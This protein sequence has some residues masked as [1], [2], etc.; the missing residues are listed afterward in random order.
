MLQ[1]AMDELFGG[2]RAQLELTGVRRP[3]AKGHLVVLQLDQAAV[4]DGD[5]ENIGGQVFQ[6]RAT[7][8]HWFA[9]NDPILLPDP[10]RYSSKQGCFDQS[11]SELAAKYLGEGLDWQ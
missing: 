6:G 8:A 10:G 1:E 9:V 3:V 4:A 11:L 5:S 7:I 2:E